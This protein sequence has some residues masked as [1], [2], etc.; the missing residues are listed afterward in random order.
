[1]ASN[2]LPENC[3]YLGLKIFHEIFLLTGQFAINI[4]AASKL[5]Q[6]DNSDTDQ[7][8]GRGSN[9]RIIDE[10]TIREKMG[11]NNDNS[12]DE[13]FCHRLDDVSRRRFR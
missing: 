11:L 6:L 2:V 8:M 1:M 3:T 5:P 12:G 10:K 9:D 4:Y 7:K 13:I